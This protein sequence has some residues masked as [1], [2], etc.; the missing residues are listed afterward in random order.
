MTAAAPPAARRVVPGEGGGGGNWRRGAHPAL[1][2]AALRPSATRCGLV[3]RWGDAA[4]TAA[5]RGVPRFPSPAQPGGKVACPNPRGR[6]W[7]PWGGRPRRAVGFP[8]PPIFFLSLSGRGTAGAPPPPSASA[9]E[10]AA[11]AVPHLRWPLSPARGGSVAPPLTALAVSSQSS[12]PRQTRVATRSG[13]GPRG[14]CGATWA[15]VCELPR[16]VVPCAIWAFAFPAACVH[17]MTTVLVF[18]SLFSSSFFFLFLL[19]HLHLVP[20]MPGRDPRFPWAVHV[21]PQ[22]PL[23]AGMRHAGRPEVT[24]HTDH[25]AAH[26]S[27][28]A[29]AAAAAASLRR[30]VCPRADGP[31]VSNDECLPN[32]CSLS[33]RWLGVG[34]RR[35][36]SVSR[37]ATPSPTSTTWQTSGMVV[38][39]TETTVTA[40]LRDP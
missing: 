12:L 11:A 27:G 5:A 36:C 15:A 26:P 24:A 32:V 7:S 20:T 3:R 4:A 10:L 23:L 14:G 2:V 30:H 31:T 37:R 8:L 40:C 34:G 13:C 9:F 22:P 29:N 21:P 6:A 35:S 1:L 33:V 18:P 38:P 25:P 39:Q 28:M 16:V 19:C 17:A